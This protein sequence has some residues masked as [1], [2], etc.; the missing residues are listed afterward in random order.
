M[1]QWSPQLARVATDEQLYLCILV[2]HDHT[3]SII[4]SD[5]ISTLK[6]KLQ[7]VGEEHK[8][9]MANKRASIKQLHD[10]VRRKVAKL[11]AITDVLHQ[12]Q[13]DHLIDAEIKTK[14]AAKFSGLKL[15]LLESEVCNADKTTSRRYS[16]DVLQ[17]AQMLHFL[18]PKV[19]RFVRKTM[20]LPCESTLQSRQSVNGEPG[21]T[22]ETFA[23]LNHDSN[24]TD[25]V[26]L[27][28]AMHLKSS[29]Q[30]SPALKRF[31]GYEDFGNGACEEGDMAREVLV[32]LAVGLTR[33]WRAPL[34]YFLTAKPLSAEQQ[35]PIVREALLRL[36]AVNVRARCV[37]FDGTN[38]NKATVE[39]LG[40]D[41]PDRPFFQHPSIDDAVVYCIMDNAHMVK[42]AR[43]TLAKH[44]MKNKDGKVISWS[45][46]KELHSLQTKEGLRFANKLTAAHVDEWHRRKMKVKLAVQV[47]SQ[48]VADALQ[49]L[50]DQGHPNFAGAM[51][52]IA[53]CRL[54]NS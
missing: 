7:Q 16:D 33:A 22:A 32:L 18:S 41:L 34:A 15:S 9:S 46:I 37:V 24:K 1:T 19:Y 27:M 8:T 28:D 13:H 12:L 26:L 30:W 44:A 5:S 20:S 45:Y 54:I 35:M 11:S 4:S 51:A 36:A 43:N 6:R 52:T 39:L 49:F 48:S 10:S 53:F 38:A 40:A 2:A 25:C 17:F 23:A 50:L 21:W 3:Y 47:L 14:L 29:V 31:V 42:L